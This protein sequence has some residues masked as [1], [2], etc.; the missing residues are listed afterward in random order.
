MQLYTL[1]LGKG[2]KASCIHNNCITDCVHC[3]YLY[4]LAEPKPTHKTC[5]VSLHPG[6]RFS[7]WL[8]FVN[9]QYPPRRR[10]VCSA[11]N[12]LEGRWSCCW[13]RPELPSGRGFRQHSRILHWTT[14]WERSRAAWSHSARPRGLGTLGTPLHRS[15]LLPVTVAPDIQP[16]LEGSRTLPYTKLQR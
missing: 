15:T 14:A 6:R 5:T 12:T 16:V 7:V 10:W 9:Q 3:I 8:R 2:S 13:S 1:G 11:G 4:M